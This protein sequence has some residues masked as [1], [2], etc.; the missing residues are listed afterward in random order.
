MKTFRI[1]FRRDIVTDLPSFQFT[2]DTASI[3]ADGKFFEQATLDFDSDAGQ[4]KI[5]PSIMRLQ[6]DLF[7]YNYF[8]FNTLTTNRDE[9][10]SG[11]MFAIT[12]YDKDS[13]LT[14][15]KLFGQGI[16]LGNISDFRNPAKNSRGN[17]LV[18]SV[19]AKTW[20]GGVND[21]ALSRTSWTEKIK[22]SVQY[23]II[24]DS[25]VTNKN[26]SKFRYQIYEVLGP[27]TLDKLFDT[28]QIDAGEFD[29]NPSKTGICIGHVFGNKNAD[30]WRLEFTNVKVIWGPYLTDDAVPV[31]P[32]TCPRDI[33]C[34]SNKGE[35]FEFN[36]SQSQFKIG[37]DYGEIE[38]TPNGTPILG[39][40][41]YAV[42][43]SKGYRIQTPNT[44]YARA[45][46]I[47]DLGI[48]FKQPED[49]LLR[50]LRPN[51][52]ERRGYDSWSVSVKGTVTILHDI[53][54]FEE[55]PT[56]TIN[57]TI[58]DGLLNFGNTF[59]SKNIND[60][61][62]VLDTASFTKFKLKY[63]ELQ[64]QRTNRKNI[65]FVFKL[66]QVL[67]NLNS[68]ASIQ[69]QFL[70]GSNVELSVN[71]PIDID[72]IDCCGDDIERL[73]PS[74]LTEIIPTVNLP[75]I[76]FNLN[77]NVGSVIPVTY[78]G[79]NGVVSVSI[80]PALPLG[81]ALNKQTGEITGT[82][83]T[84]FPPTEF[85]VTFKDVRNETSSETFIMKVDSGA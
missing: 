78:V 59:P 73:P 75:S 4:Y 5:S 35:L 28:G 9:Q 19:Q 15:K 74:P 82:P 29:F 8:S 43:T 32:C 1:D 6:F 26:T 55:G 77:K 54:E 51:I 23:R 66:S 76:I 46:A 80:S 11:H 45:P 63:K 21:N 58:T 2:K 38:Q 18:P 70:V 30:V 69:E 13:V 31:D 81:L 62:L 68:G 67:Y 72:Q 20:A 7:S 65:F 84:V 57:K 61:N 16:V 33:V 44:R 71:I 50:N 48:K 25:I 53:I 40:R 42:K 3:S 85:T 47:L 39:F 14:K 52:I 27:D 37:F 56:L 34:Y 49:V 17:S 22:D 41:D 12:R 60:S 83:L 64:N 10:G 24:F 79:G 36:N